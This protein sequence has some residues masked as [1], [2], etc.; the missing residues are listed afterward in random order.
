L[1]KSAAHDHGARPVALA[2]G[3]A[4][5]VGSESGAVAGLAFI[6]Q[7]QGHL[8]LGSEH[9]LI[10]FNFQIVAQI[11]TAHRCFTIAA[12]S[13]AAEKVLENAAASAHGAH[14]G[15]QRFL[16]IDATAES[17][18]TAAKPA[19]AGTKRGRAVLVIP[20]AFVGIAED[21]IGLGDFLEFLLGV[22]VA[23]VFVRVK[24]NGQFAVGLFD[25]VRARVAGDADRGVKILVLRGHG[26]FPPSVADP[27]ETT[28]C[29][30]RIN[31][32]P[33]L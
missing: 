6:H 11:G 22:F 3:F 13:A 23:G 30:G 14:E 26:Q 33:S 21:F 10:E 18:G 5:A 27:L 20:L 29:S 31:L 24:L 16:E 32:S 7:R 2:A 25:V 12:P 15:A 8:V 1:K 17:A 19:A 4:F 28:T 9:R